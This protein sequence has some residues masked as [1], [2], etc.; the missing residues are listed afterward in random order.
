MAE[1][2]AE[3]GTDNFGQANANAAVEAMTRAE[4]SLEFKAEAEARAVAAAAAARLRLDIEAELAKLALEEK[5]LDEEEVRPACPPKD[6]KPCGVSV[7][8]SNRDNLPP[9]L[10][11]RTLFASTS[12]HR[13]FESRAANLAGCCRESRGGGCIG[14]KEGSC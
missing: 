13:L 14:S 5:A 12:H 7:P 8:L 9:H 3:K 11:R 4:E 6:A 10:L 2:T 1:V